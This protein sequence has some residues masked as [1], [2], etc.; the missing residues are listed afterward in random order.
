[1]DSGSSNLILYYYR[2]P[3]ACAVTKLAR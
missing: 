2:G 3:Q 1:M